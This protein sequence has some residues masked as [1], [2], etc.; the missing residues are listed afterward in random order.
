MDRNGSSCVEAKPLF[1]M[2]FHRCFVA[3][4]VVDRSGEL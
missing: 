4:S 1:W 2:H 3:L